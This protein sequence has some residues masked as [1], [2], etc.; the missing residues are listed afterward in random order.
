M[1]L[2][3]R[4]T[5]IFPCDKSLITRDSREE[6]RLSGEQCRTRG[7]TDSEQLLSEK[8]SLVQ[9]DNIMV[10]R[11]FHLQTSSPGTG[12]RGYREA[13]WRPQGINAFSQLF[14]DGSF[15][16]L[17]IGEAEKERSEEFCQ[18]LWGESS[19]ISSSSCKVKELPV[20]FQVK[21]KQS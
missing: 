5:H 16:M 21:Q 13:Q 1:H 12:C 2:I 18:V 15:V 3:I 20:Y 11:F 7:I 14:P 19:M 6:R 4:Y 17:C 9:M 10:S 8:L